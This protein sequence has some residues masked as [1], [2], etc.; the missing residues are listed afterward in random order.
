MIFIAPTVLACAIAEAIPAE[1]TVPIGTVASSAEA[2]AVATP[3]RDALLFEGLLDDPTP[4]AHPEPRATLILSTVFACPPPE[5]T[6]ARADIVV[7]IV[8]L[9]AVPEADARVE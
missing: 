5:A 6:P 9:F 4:A 7:R 2:V 8:A 3:M 1:V